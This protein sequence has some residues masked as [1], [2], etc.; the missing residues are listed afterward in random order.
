MLSNEYFFN[1]QVSLNVFNEQVLNL[2]LA[3]DLIYLH[4]ED[5]WTFSSIHRITSKNECVSDDPKEKE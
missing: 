1:E 4:S 5:S 2:D 3:T